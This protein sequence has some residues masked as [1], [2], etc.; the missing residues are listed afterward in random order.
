MSG[1]FMYLKAH[2]MCNSRSD[3]KTISPSIL[4][5]IMRHEH[6]ALSE[7]GREY[8]CSYCNTYHR[9]R[10]FTQHAAVCKRNKQSLEAAECWHTEKQIQNQRQVAESDNRLL[11]NLDFNSDEQYMTDEMMA[12]HLGKQPDM[13]SVEYEGSVSVESED[14][15]DETD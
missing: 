3:Q 10:G 4:T 12:A 14:S 6:H 9:I 11:A 7:T 15:M 1:G 5:S 2:Q 13:V 8:W